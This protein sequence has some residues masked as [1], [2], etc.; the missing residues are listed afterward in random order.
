MDVGRDAEPP[1]EK[2]S[3]ASELLF[4]NRTLEVFQAKGSREGEFARALSPPT[5]PRAEVNR[6]GVALRWTSPPGMTAVRSSLGDHPLLELTYRVYRWREAEAPASI[7]S[8]DITQTFYLDQDLPLWSER[9]YYC[10]A[11]VL[12]GKMEDLPTLIESRPS[13]V[14]SVQTSQNFQLSILSGTPD[15]AHVEVAAFQDGGW[16]RREFAVTPGARIGSGAAETQEGTT[17]SEPD[18]DTGLTVLN[19][20]VREESGE[21]RVERPIFLPDGRREVDPASGLPTF[22]SVNEPVQAR[23]VEL[24]C[25]DP[26]GDVKRIS[27]SPTR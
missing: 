23:V 9:Y 20:E 8:V 21:V 3:F 4:A 14:I 2:H 15:L 10:V 26:A 11:T 24:E 16:R 1:L 19:I 22:R 12:E 18:F 27:S 17:E 5:P 25:L 6:D 7:G 13:S